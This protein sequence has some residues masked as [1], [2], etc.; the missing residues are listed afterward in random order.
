MPAGRHDRR[1]F[2][3][4]R[5]RTMKITTRPRHRGRTRG[6]GFKRTPV[7]E[8]LETRNLLACSFGE[9]EGVLT[10]VGDT[11][12]EVLTINDDGTGTAGNVVARC[13]GM[14][15]VSRDAVR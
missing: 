7:L 13:G 2:I 12:A 5:G 8:P 11:R 14:T 1:G 9:A 4:A 10:I 3:R 15:Y 6:P